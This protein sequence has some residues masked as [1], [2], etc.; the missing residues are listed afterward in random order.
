MGGHALAV[1]TDRIADSEYCKACDFLVKHLA[2]IVNKVFIPHAVPG[3]KDHGDIDMVVV[4]KEMSALEIS[5]SL[6]S[7]VY[8]KNG[9]CFS[10]GLPFNNN[11]IQVD[12]IQ[13][14]EEYFDLQC[15]Y[16]SWGDL[17]NL[18]GRVAVG[19]LRLH[20]GW[21]RMFFRYRA[22]QDGEAAD[23]NKGQFG[24]WSKDYTI[25]QNFSECMKILGYD[26]SRFR[27]GFSSK[28]DI[29]DF[30]MSSKLAHPNHFIFENL[31]HEN[32]SRNRERPNYVEFVQWVSQFKNTEPVIRPS[33]DKTVQY[34]DNHYSLGIHR[35]IL[36]MKAQSLIIKAQS[37]RLNGDIVKNISGK[38]GKEI[39]II[40][41]KVYDTLGLSKKNRY[42]QSLILS[43]ISDKEIEDAI[44]KASDFSQSST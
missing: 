13:S 9:N 3:K 17:G 43:N 6:G 8:H 42:D 30:V 28:K 27:S 40:I 10:F 11:L 29:W 41:N 44:K 12:L 39:G 4:L 21:D 35:D 5:Q 16:Q 19:A 37:R 36:N 24:S 20:Y 26:E 33:I 18:M 1:P 7:S 31:D 38:E 2:P 34:L 22:Q 32:R 15:Q 14:K 23:I 25:T